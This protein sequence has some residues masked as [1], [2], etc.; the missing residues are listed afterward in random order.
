MK[1][2]VPE[3]PAIV[4]ACAPFRVVLKPIFA[5]FEV[6]KLVP[7]KLTG[8]PNVSVF[9]PET[10]IFAPTWT[11][12][13]LVKIRLVKGVV[14]PTAPENETTP[15]VPAWRVNA[16]A[17][18]IVLVK[19]IFAPAGVPVAFVLSSVIGTVR[20]TGPVIVMTPPEVVSFPF[21]LIAV[22]PV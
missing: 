4:S 11:V 17:P 15:A 1:V 13:A 21:K 7:V 12:F 16:A 14:P 18:L 20:T 9:A 6:I 22:V 8:N 2:V 5:L 19:L 3:P 10:V